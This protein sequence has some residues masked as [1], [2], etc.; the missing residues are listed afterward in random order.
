MIEKESTPIQHKLF[1]PTDLV[2]ITAMSSSKYHQQLASCIEQIHELRS[3][4]MLV[5]V[6][7]IEALLELEQLLQQYC[8]K[9]QVELLAQKGPNMGRKIQRR[10]YENKNAILLGVY[11][12]WEGFDASGHVIDSLVITKLPFPNP[13]TR[14]QQIVQM[15][16]EVQERNYFSQYAI[17]MMLLQLYQGLGRFSRP[18]QQNSDIWI[19]DVRAS[20]SKYAS[21]VKNQLT[22]EYKLIEKPFNKCLHVSK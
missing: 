7:S 2:S 20:I 22:K 5:L 12:F 19:L 14:E 3:G 18:V 6:H 15:E 11:S 9:N 17:K 16:M 21:Q 13:Y 10:F 8:Q 1:L 4:R